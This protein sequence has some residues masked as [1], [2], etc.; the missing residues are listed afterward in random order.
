MKP[1][2]AAIGA[3]AIY[4]GS[5][6]WIADTSSA[7]TSAAMQALDGWNIVV[8]ADSVSTST[9]ADCGQ[10]VL[11]YEPPRLVFAGEPSPPLGKHAIGW[12]MPGTGTAV[13][14]TFVI[15][16][17]ENLSELSI[18]ILSSQYHDYGLATVYLPDQTGNGYWNGLSG[19][20]GMDPGT[21]NS[22]DFTDQ[23]FG[24][25]HH[26][27][28]DVVD[29]YIVGRTIS[30]MANAQAGSPQA[31]VGLLYG[32]AG[33]DIYFDELRVGQFGVT[34]TYNYEGYGS[35]TT[36]AQ[37][38]YSIT[39]GDSVSI[40]GDAWDLRGAPIAA[41]LDFRAR[42]SG[43]SRFVKVGSANAT[44]HQHARMRVTPK[45]STS[46]RVLFPGDAAYNSSSSP[47]VVVEVLKAVDAKLARSTIRRGQSMTV[48]GTVGPQTRGLPVQLQ[49]WDA[50]RWVTW[51]RKTTG[52]KG[53]YA[54]NVRPSSAGVVILRVVAAQAKGTGRGVSPVK[55]FTVTS[56]AP[57][58][59]PPSEP[60]PPPPPVIPPPP[61]I[62]T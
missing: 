33:G 45:A 52:A 37:S 19:Y 32:C 9:S 57:P 26:N 53:R 49:R 21:W 30:E 62:K 44:A 4:L 22:Y 39:Y 18:K 6:A 27:S 8:L 46:Y 40:I 29:D 47:T 51:S 48:K 3:L 2:A 17:P 58:P 24:W 56:P 14:P 35:S 28:Q 12:Q 11:T 61:P 13:G 59:P 41:K 15:S 36:I 23:L 55:R 34:D 1:R 43:K 25:Y 10:L 60:P 16:S 20:G 54:F 5:M 31:S 42:A 50:H 7:T 38:R